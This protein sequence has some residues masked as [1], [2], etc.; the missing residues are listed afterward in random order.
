MGGGGGSPHLFGLVLLCGLGTPKST[1]VGSRGSFY[2]FPLDSRKGCETQQTTQM[3]MS[4]ARRARRPLTLGSR[5]R[6]FENGCYWTRAR[7][8]SPNFWV[9]GGFALVCVG[10]RGPPGDP[11]KPRDGPRRAS[12]DLPGSSGAPGSGPKNANTYKND[13]FLQ[14]P[15]RRPSLR[16]HQ[17]THDGFGGERYRTFIFSIPRS[18]A[19][20]DL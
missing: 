14:G 9:S 5:L 15:S 12:G 16:T 11:R 17:G 3:S 20:G 6:L 7:P 10:S 4:L 1:I 2:Q 13:Y 18:V 8:L 19:T